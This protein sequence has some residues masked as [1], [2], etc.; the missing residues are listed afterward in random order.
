MAEE[1]LGLALLTYPERGLPLPKPRHK[2]RGL[3]PIAPE[4]E[5]AAKL[6]VLDAFREAGIAKT[7]LARRMGKDEKEVR[8]IPRPQAGHQAAGT[9]QRPARARET[10]GD[11]HR[12]GG[13]RHSRQS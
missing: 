6:A 11:Q 5:I 10:P 13:L 3:V 12:R 7:E 9:R 2:G 8:R 1:A 4:A